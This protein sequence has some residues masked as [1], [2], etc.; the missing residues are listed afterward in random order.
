MV[1]YTGG[2]KASDNKKG[3]EPP[4]VSITRLPLIWQALF[5]HKLSVCTL[6]TNGLHI[7]LMEQSWGIC[8]LPGRASDC[9]A[10]TNRDEKHQSSSYLNWP[11]TRFFNRLTPLNVGVGFTV[12]G[13]TFRSRTLVFPGFWKLKI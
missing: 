8:W 11:S 13:H 10:Q 5:S 4:V 1:S 9:P 2:W 3:R 6:S 12:A 7:K